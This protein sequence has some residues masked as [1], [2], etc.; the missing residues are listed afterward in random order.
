M[1]RV[2][3]NESNGILRL[4]RRAGRWRVAPSPQHPDRQRWRVE[5]SKPADREA[6][7]RFERQ[8]ALDRPAGSRSRCRISDKKV[9]L[10]VTRS[11]AVNTGN[12][13]GAGTNLVTRSGFPKSNAGTGVP[14]LHLV[15]EYDPRFQV[16]QVSWSPD[17]SH[18]AYIRSEL[19]GTRGAVGP[20]Q[21][22]IGRFPEDPE[23][24]GS[25]PLRSGSI[26]D[27]SVT[28]W[29]VSTNDGADYSQPSWNSEGNMVIYTRRN[30][31]ILHREGPPSR[32][33]R[34]GSQVDRLDA[35]SSVYLR[36]VLPRDPSAKEVCISTDLS[37]NHRY[38][39]FS[40]CPDS[41]F[42]SYSRVTRADTGLRWQIWIRQLRRKRC[43]LH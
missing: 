39:S 3:V 36:K 40:P 38:P 18:F 29:K 30:R 1:S 21:L 32:L 20:G 31:V 25:W 23:A 26:S 41:C 12:G 24:Q 28:T 4:P 17:G 7:V 37:A 43:P 19:L 10:A 22:W 16:G 11:C 35:K 13:I 2:R 9:L 42:A 14:P 15:T 27:P 6:A 33:F 5:V 34:I 8:A